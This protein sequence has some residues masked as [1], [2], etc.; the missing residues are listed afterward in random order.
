MQQVPSYSTKQSSSSFGLFFISFQQSLLF[1][2]SQ[3]A[4]FFQKCT[5]F[6]KILSEVINP[7]EVAVHGGAGSLVSK[8]LS[9]GKSLI[10]GFLPSFGSKSVAE[11]KEG[12]LSVKEIKNILT[13]GV[14]ATDEQIGKKRPTFL[15][16]FILTFDFFRVIERTFS[17]HEIDSIPSL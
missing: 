14:M 16:L 6:V 5:T 7:T 8:V 11:N 4:T 1:H 9:A 3:F 10:S 17:I 2:L 15:S 12:S 13:S